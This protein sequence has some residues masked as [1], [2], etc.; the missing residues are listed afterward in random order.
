MRLW[1][2]LI[3]FVFVCT[4]LLNHSLGIISLDAAEAGRLVF[5]AV[6]GNPL[7]TLRAVRL[8]CSPT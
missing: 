7:G 3:I 5:L 8:R 2:G 4:H 6:W 1:S